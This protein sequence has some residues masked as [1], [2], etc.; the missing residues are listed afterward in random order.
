M[1]LPT[2]WH[3][4]IAIGAAL[5]VFAGLQWRRGAATDVLFLS[6]LVAITLLGVISPDEALSGFAN[7]A[8]I[9]IAGLLVVAAGL[10]TTGVLDW[11]GR[12]LLGAASTE[13]QTLW[14]LAPFLL[15][16]SAVLLNTA[17]VAMM[18]PIVLDHGRRRGIAPSRL[19]I[20][21]S[22][23]TIL[24]GVCTLIGTSTTLVVNGY[25]GTFDL[26]PLGFFEI[27]Y[28][29]LPCAVIGGLFILLIAPRL[30]PE[31]GDLVRELGEHRREY[32]VEMSV[33]PECP[34]VGRTIEE[35][36]LRQLP[37]LFLIEIDRRGDV[38]TPVA[39]HDRIEA[40]DR[41]VFTGIVSTIVDLEKIPGLVPAADL[42]YEVDPV[43]RSQRHLTEVVL[44]RTSPLIGTTVREARFRQ[45]YNAAVVAVHRNGVRLTNK[46][47]DVVLEPGDTLLLQTRSEFLSSY[48]NSR[49]FYLVSSV[50]G[51]EPRRHD[52]TRL[53]GCLALVLVAW[54]AASSWL[55]GA[56]GTPALVALAVALVMLLTRCLRPAEARAALDLQLLLTIGAA[57]GM[58][59]AL[60]RSGAA[61]MVAQGLVRAVGQN[62]HALLVTM[63]LFT[64]VVTEL[65]TN[66]AVAAIMLPIGVSMAQ[67]GGYSERPFVMAIV[68]AASLSFMTPIGYQTNLM[69]MGPGGY[70]A[71]DYLRC[72][73]P[74]AIVLAATALI[75][76]PIVFPF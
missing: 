23:L 38:M 9:A 49:D 42:A 29:G 31:H 35:A 43:A 19:L 53:A 17:V 34:L 73:V 63:Y 66:N 48:R 12:W 16:S 15:A 37:G 13:R 4:W 24:G 27:G 41:L 72:G 61:E 55:D 74:L 62:P 20:P 5:A 40:F 11:L 65:M 75:S 6:G 18:L 7:P 58:G 25:L 36:G 26:E 1:G 14:R 64:M 54:L 3:P 22:Y 76:L 45:L 67:A 2:A 21:L 44:S 28:V 60:Y 50:D 46:I 8:L 57:L 33:R 52:K 39:P 70:R 69:V 51:W 71:G 59:Q 10:R 47:G 56:W 30:L 32:L 68:L